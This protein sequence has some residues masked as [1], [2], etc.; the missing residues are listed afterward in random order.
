MGEEM[1]AQHEVL[2]DAIITPKEQKII[3]AIGDG[4]KKLY[5]IMTQTGFG[6][7]TVMDSLKE[8][9]MMGWITYSEQW[10]TW[11][12]NP[13]VTFRCVRIRNGEVMDEQER[14]SVTYRTPLKA[15]YARKEHERFVDNSL[16]IGWTTPEEFQRIMAEDRKTMRFIYT[17][18]GEKLYEGNHPD[19]RPG[20][21]SGAGKTEIR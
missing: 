18:G 13:K 4:A 11:N 6:K 14:I 2:E 1:S 12:V 17:K 3:D 10:Q 9:R 21:T 19:N 8:M 7:V 20:R 16:K 5:E 15:T